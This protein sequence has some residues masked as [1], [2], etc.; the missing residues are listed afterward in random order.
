MGSEASLYTPAHVGLS[1]LTLRPAACRT[2]L[3]HAELTT[4][5]RPNLLATRPPY[6]IKK[7]KQKTKKTIERKIIQ[8]LEFSCAT[9][10]FDAS[11]LDL[12]ILLS[13]TLAVA[14]PI[15]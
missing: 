2:R 9:L 1:A 14:F 6:F 10:F 11:F 12:V 13:A 15:L 3:T 5:G 4:L 7:Y 8:P